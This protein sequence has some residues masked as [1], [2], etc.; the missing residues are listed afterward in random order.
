MKT[1]YTKQ[2]LSFDQQ[3]KLLIQRGLIIENPDK[4][5]HL[6]ESVSYYRLSAYWHPF[7]ADKQNH[8][9][10]AGSKFENIF[11]LYCFDRE[12]RS[13][14]ISEVEK[15]EIAV[16]AKMIYVLSRKFGPFGYQNPSLYK[17]HQKFRVQLMS[18]LMDEYKRSDEEFIKAFKTR[19]IELLPPS[20]MAMEIISFGT[21]SKLFSGL[22][23]GKEKREIAGHFGLTDTVFGNWLHCLVYLRNICAH[24]SR[25]WNRVLSIRPQIP[26]SPRRPYIVNT[27]VS[28]DRTYYVL[29]MIRYLLQSVNPNSGFVGK[30]KQLL[31][32][33]P[34]ANLQAMGFPLS[35]QNESFW[36]K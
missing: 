18:K 10:K 36:Q 31:N 20:W 3:L 9:F 2:A 6:L 14:I 19:Y 13:L 29:C 27:N 4:T 16:R 35:W 5:L 8:L 34:S 21:L 17:D 32:K 15:I 26:L 12:L 1:H 7:L 24:H 30:L 25:L 22:K 33:Y 28:S 11:S 23:P